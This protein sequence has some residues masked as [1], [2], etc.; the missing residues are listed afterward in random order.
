MNLRSSFFFYLVLSF[1]FYLKAQTSSLS[2]DQIM[3]GEKYT[4]YSPNNISW[5]LDSKTVYFDWNPEMKNQMQPFKLTLDNK[6]PRPVPLEEQKFRQPLGGVYDVARKRYVY[7]KEGDIYMVDLDKNS[8]RPI[9]FTNNYESNPVFVDQ[10]RKIAFESGSNIFV[11]DILSGE[12]RQLSNFTKGNKKPEPK[13]SLQ[14][15]LLERQQLELFGIVKKQKSNI[16]EQKALRDSLKIRKLKEFYFGDKNIQNLTLSPDMKSL[17]FR[18]EKP[19]DFKVADVPNYVTDNGFSRNIPTREK[20]GGSQDTYELYRYD[21]IK[22]TAILFDRTQLSG[23]FNLPEYL[24]DYHEQDSSFT[25]IRTMPKDVIY[26]GPFFNAS[27]RAVLDIKSLDHKDRWII[28][29]EPGE[30]KYKIIDHQHD[31]AWVGGPGILGWIESPGNVFWYDSDRKIAFQSEKTGYSQLY[32]YDLASDIVEN[33][34]SGN[35]E[36]LDASLAPNKSSFYVTSN[37]VSPAEHQFYHFMPLEKSWRQITYS[38]G[39][40][41]VV[42]SPDGKWLAIRYSYSNKPWELYLMENKA[43]AK[44]LAITDSRTSDF[45]SYQWREPELVS[46]RASD[47]AMVPARLYKPTNP[48]GAAVMFVHG[49]GYLQNVHKWWSNYYREYMFHNKLCDEGYTVIDIDY[50]ASDGYGRDWRTAIYRYMGNR[51]LDDY[52][53]GVKYLSENC[54][55][56]PSRVGIYGGSYGGFITLM[57]MFTRPGVFKCGAALRSVTDWAHYNH[58]YTSAILNTPLEDSISYKRSSP[59]Y[60]ADGLQGRLL[61]LHGVL[62]LN[63]HYQD[64]VRLSQRLIELRKENW[65]LASFPVEDHGFKEP[66]GWADEYKRI[67]KLFQEELLKE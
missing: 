1:G 11:W 29:L 5:S 20:V 55:V 44:E 47:G 23:I 35:F 27:G 48:N 64:I 33:L 18:L 15:G 30:L 28:L 40:H 52:V 58:G 53:D 63:V 41:E 12:T 38:A 67:Y 39:N 7:E 65:E 26:H 19:A 17:Y 61:M 9:T 34:T 43:G 51:D 59:I 46:F 32:S 3:M 36:I 8:V 31:E 10:D 60:F 14:E 49:A 22:D 37:E 57:G 45:K 4:G 66:T 16:Q 62:D 54:G 6:I 13:K 24:K 50:R 56:D 21:L 25:N 2:I 42:P